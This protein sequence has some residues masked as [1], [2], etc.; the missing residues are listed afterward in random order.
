VVEG[1]VFATIFFAGLAI[2][3][4]LNVVIHRGPVMWGLVDAPAR[5]NLAS[6]RS[7][8]PSCKTRLTVLNLLPLISYVVQR[9]Q[10]ANCGA[11]ISARYPI[12]EIMGAASLLLAV[13]SF[14]FTP[15][16]P[17]AAAFAFALIALAFIDLETG[18]L[19][20]AL[21]APLI[22]LGLAANAFGLFVT[23]ADAAI[24]AVAGY[25]IFW[26]IGVAYQRW[27]GREGLGLGDAKLLAAIGA[28]TGWMGL[29]MVIFV[30]ALGT[31][32]ATG[33]LWL[34]GRKPTHDQP[35]PF[36]PGLCAAG[37]ATLF[38]GERLLSAL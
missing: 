28:W 19:P 34:A 21:T 24:G 2:G 14:G 15:A 9:G 29:P 17:C 33:V 22:A 10:C 7:Y 18:Y 11:R 30:A 20:D 31:L 3:S 36:G 26:L 38:I 37:V 23:F 4:F 5:G 1:V 6:P 32:A 25:S 27:R 35:I 16:A 8:C 13:A 12:V